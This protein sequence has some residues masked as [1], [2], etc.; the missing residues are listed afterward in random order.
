[1]QGTAGY[2]QL[3]I[4]ALSFR[5]LQ[6][7]LC[8]V[9]SVKLQCAADFSDDVMQFELIDGSGRQAVFNF[10]CLLVSSVVVVVVCARHVKCSTVIECEGQKKSDTERCRDREPGETKLLTC[11][12]NPVSRSA[13]VC[14]ATSSTL[15]VASRGKVKGIFFGRWLPL[16]NADCLA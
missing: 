1:M 10:V 13:R 7:L 12:S 3:P 6:A 2:I 4:V 16:S 9:S 15:H 5:R 11:D 14:C 8:T